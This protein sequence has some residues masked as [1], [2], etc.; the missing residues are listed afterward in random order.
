[1]CC[2]RCTHDAGSGQTHLVGIG[3]DTELM[4]IGDMLVEGAF[5]PEA[6]FGTTDAGMAGLDGERQTAVLTDGRTGVVGG[7][8]LAAHLV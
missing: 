5:I 3:L 7:R 6:V 4:H 1:M 2:D 8:S